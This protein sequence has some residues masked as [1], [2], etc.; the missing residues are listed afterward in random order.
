MD[1][2]FAEAIVFLAGF[3]GFLIVGGIVFGI[4]VDLIEG[5]IWK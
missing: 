1:R 4:L 5:T 3:S 2:E